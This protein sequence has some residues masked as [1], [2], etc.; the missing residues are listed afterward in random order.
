MT[1]DLTSRL[2]TALATA[3]EEQKQRAL[4]ALLGNPDDKLQQE[5]AEP[6]LTLKQVSVRLNFHPSTLWRWGVP[7]HDL[8][9]RPRFLLS[10]VRAYL[11]TD[12]FKRRAVNLRVDRK[13]RRKEQLLAL[14]AEGNKEAVADLYKEY[15]IDVKPGLNGGAS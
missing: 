3:S 15:G 1:G 11:D 7:K 4:S 6:Y 13:D 9:G 5:Q 8:G 2:L 12:E 10:E 14:A